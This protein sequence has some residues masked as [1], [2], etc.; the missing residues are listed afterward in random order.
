MAVVNFYS[1]FEYKWGQTGGII[2]LQ[3]DQYKLGWAFI[4][5]TPPSVEQFNKLQQL[6]DE[7][8]AWLWGQFKQAADARKVTIGGDDLLGLNKLLTAVTPDATTA[9]KGLAAFATDA[10][11]IALASKTKALTPYGLSLNITQ[12][13]NDVTSGRLLKVG[14]FG[15]GGVMVTPPKGR[16]N[17]NPMGLYYQASAVPFGGGSFF[18]EMPYSST[19]GG[20]RLSNDPYKD[21]YYLNSWNKDISAYSNAVELFHTGNFDPDSKADK[22]SSLPIFATTPTTDSGPVIYVIDRQQIL[23]WQTIGSFKGYAS[24]DVGRFVWGTSMSARADEVDAIGQVVA[25]TNTRYKAL[26][27]WAEAN[28]HIVAPADWKKGAFVFSKVSSSS[29]RLPDLRDQFIRATGTDA[30]TANARL[31]GSTQN[32]ATRMHPIQTWISTGFDPTGAEISL[33]GADAAGSMGELSASMFPNQEMETR[34][35]NTALHPRIQI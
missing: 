7:K 18:V 26:V 2:D 3:D 28:G 17:L 13:S 14:D 4:G 31:L 10:E 25:P 30:D 29:F 19:V 27:A 9:R 23:H 15:I 16:T 32:A 12:S 8:F 11:A 20:F 24:P 33:V 35:V 34:P 5:S 1:G 22:A 6:N 21:R